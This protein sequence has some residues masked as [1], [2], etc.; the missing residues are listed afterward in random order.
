MAELKTLLGQLFGINPSEIAPGVS[1]I[2]MGADSLFLLQVSQ[3]IR[4]RFGIKLPFR[5]MLEEY[6]TVEALAG[7][8][9]QNSSAETA[10]ADTNDT[11]DAER[12][13]EAKAAERAGTRAVAPMPE[14]ARVEY[15]KPSEAAARAVAVVR[16][17]RSAGREIAT[18]DSPAAPRTKSYEAPAAARQTQSG[19]SRQAA[20]GST[21]E[22][23]FA[24][25]LQIMSQ[26][27]EVL[28]ERQTGGDASFAAPAVERARVIP[29]RHTRDDDD[30]DAPGENG[31]A[32]RSSAT[33]NV[34]P[35]VERVEAQE[36]GAKANENGA[37][38]KEKVVVAKD[39]Q[40]PYVAYASIREGLGGGLSPRQQKHLDAL[41]ERL[42]RRTQTSKRLAQANRPVLADNRATAGFRLLW[43]EM[44]YPLLVE[45]GAGSRLWDVDGNEYVDL[46]MGFGALLFGHSPPFLVE[47]V[48]R[49]MEHGIL[50]GGTT[51]LAA[52]AAQ[53]ICE[54]TGAER[55]SFCNS[56]TEAVM[57]ALRLARTVTGRVK[58][59]VF[60]GAYHGTFD[61]VMVR[62]ERDSEGRLRAIPLAPGVP[63]HMIE[64]VLLLS[65]DD[66]KCAD[67]L[68]AHA[69]ELAAVL[70]EP[71]QNRR[72]DM[73]PAAFLKQM[74][75]V[76]EEIGAALIFDEVV[77]GFR[78]HTGGAQAVF[79]VQADLVTYGKAVG[80]GLPIGVVAGKSAYMDAIDGGMWNYGDA[81]YPQ[82]ETTFFA[83]TY[84][85]HPLIMAAVWATLDHL[86]SSGPALQ[87]KLNEETAR[88]VASLNDYFDQ[89]RVPMRVAH[90]ASLFRFMFPREAPLADIFYY[91]ML[92]Q[93]IYICETRNC[94]Y[95]TAHTAEDG[96]RILEAV[97]R[98]VAEMR[99]GGFLPDLPVSPD[100]GKTSVERFAAQPPRAD[101][102][103]APQPN[104]RS[105]PSP[106]LASGPNLGVRTIPLT[107]AQK[108]IWALAQINEE[109]SC[110]YNQ[111]FAVRLRGAFRPD[112][113]RG[114]VQELLGR[115]E[116]LRITVHPDGEQ[117]QVHPSMTLEV[118]LIDLSAIDPTERDERVNEL[119]AEESR[120]AFDL[121]KGPLVR[122]R[123]LKLEEDLHLLVLTM[124]HLVTDGWSNS[125]LLHELSALYLARCQ[126]TESHL[127]PPAQFGEYALRETS[128]QLVEESGEDESYWLAQFADAAPILELPTDRP[129]PPQK[130]YRA[131]RE[132]LRVDDS[133][134]D[135]LKKFS[136]RQGS[137]MF[138]A[139]LAGF[140]VLLHR[141]SQQ[142]DIVVGI[143]AAGQLASGGQDLVGYCI[144]LLP[145]RSRI[146]ADPTFAAYLAEVKQLVL[147]AY[148]HQRYPLR[149]LIKRLN[150]P[151]DPSRLPLISAS[152]NLDKARSAPRSFTPDAV[153]ATRPEA[154]SHALEVEFLSI[155]PSFVQWELYFNLIES[156]DELVLE[157]DYNT[158]LFNAGTIRHWMESYVELLAHVVARPL[159]TVGALRQ[160]LDEMSARQQLFKEQTL[161]EARLSKFGKMKRR[162]S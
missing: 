51:P 8:I 154:R 151:R 26:Q 111:S 2:E 58:I 18:P 37:E 20:H 12:S 89:E 100:G 32:S 7:Y 80:A 35:A 30:S 120:R 114:A 83:G 10:S 148:K 22:R 42:T 142:D 21:L 55:A 19:N 48:Q 132:R 117:Q 68:R 82:A 92:E 74:R 129:R 86:K 1:L 78:F 112:A 123:I 73:Q 27:L 116:A 144:N 70:L 101:S 133:L 65:P 159:S 143:T 128:G 124:H 136:A 91:H 113:M 95:S 119:L 53:A 5:M 79:G 38:A 126:G 3:A 40:K 107:D 23:I 99:E 14:P 127:P 105:S 149:R 49:Q 153:S 139:L 147:D 115:H 88:L 103:R 162:A 109:A 106:A 6:S 45:H 160:A 44:Q 33:L 11:A 140:N 9:A 134:H 67:I 36:N 41:V 25:Q 125:I 155:P 15:E 96:E 98:C 66:P 137:T 121:V 118:A 4:D 72:P 77:S 71:L 29:A 52:K 16:T 63:P 17:A 84:F 69:G 61:G 46:A 156:E 146:H 43:K 102:T 60:E 39:K 158:D 62:G 135:G 150:L 85:K 34:P 94:L 54:L 13:A 47:A 145:L 108:G 138:M 104:G 75:E 131:A 130:T 50:L 28:H 31:E 110:A 56:G 87:E 141:L 64:N 157:C 97:K 93:G 57:S 152:F 90:F 76:T 59:A 161:E 24:Q 122:S 81:S